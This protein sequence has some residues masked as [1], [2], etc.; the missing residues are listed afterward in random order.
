[1]TI[2]FRTEEEQE[3]LNDHVR[4]KEV[5]EWALFQSLHA[6]PASAGQV[7]R[8]LATAP[9]E[10]FVLLGGLVPTAALPATQNE[11]LHENPIVQ[12]FVGAVRARRKQDRR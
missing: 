10:V 6:E 11:S 5:L 4:R 8:F 3:Q 2:N 9:P 12:G 7:K 1:M